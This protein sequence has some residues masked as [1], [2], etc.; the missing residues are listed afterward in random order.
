MHRPSWWWERQLAHARE[1]LA[2][3]DKIHTPE[4]LARARSELAVCPRERQASLPLDDRR[5][6][7]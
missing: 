2:L 4:E 1:C 6:R 3:C 5:G 7:D